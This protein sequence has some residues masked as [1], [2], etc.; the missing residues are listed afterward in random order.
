MGPPL[1]LEGTEDRLTICSEP[2]LSSH[3]L[4]AFPTWATVAFLGHF[5]QL[6]ALQLAKGEGVGGKGGG[7]LH[8]G[9]AEVRAL[10]PLVAGESWIKISIQRNPFPHLASC[11]KWSTLRP[12]CRERVQV[13]P[14]LSIT[15]KLHG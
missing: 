12:V 2:V 4:P 8:T 13:L 14:H 10:Y 7:G 15:N 9:A 5:Q 11:A 6:P 3:L 1:L